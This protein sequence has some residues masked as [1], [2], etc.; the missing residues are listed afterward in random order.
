MADHGFIERKEA[1]R[2]AA[3]P[4][5]LARETGAARGLAAE[6]VDVVAHALADKLG[7]SA[8][9]E[10]GDDRHD[11]AGREAAGAGARRRS[12]AGWRS[13][14]RARVSAARRGT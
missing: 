9:F 2:I 6:E 12:S 8:A 7:E 3:Q 11:D 5:R 10:V 14:T 1:E 4:I 13:S